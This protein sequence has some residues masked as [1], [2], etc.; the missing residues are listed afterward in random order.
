MGV[1]RGRLSSVEYRRVIISVLPRAYYFLGSRKYK[2]FLT[3]AQQSTAQQE[4]QRMTEALL[5]NLSTIICFRTGSPADEELLLSRFTPYIELG[6]ISNLPTYNFYARLSAITPQE[7]VSGMTLLLEDKGSEEI[8]QKVIDASRA[9]CATEYVAKKK[10]KS[11]PK[12]NE[13]KQEEST[14]DELPDVHELS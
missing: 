1:C 10:S 9:N 14:D 12:Q 5:S 2:L 4:T 8:V 13:Q 3:I 6:E 7:P 11:Q